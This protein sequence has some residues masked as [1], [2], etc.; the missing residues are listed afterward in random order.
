MCDL[1]STDFSIR[2]M[3]S[4]DAEA[5]SMLVTELGYR[6]TA[7]GVRQWIESLR[8]DGR[9]QTAFV[10]CEGAS[11]IGWV[12][13]SIEHRLQSPPFAL[14]G[15]LVVKDGARSRGV[16]RAL[17]ARAEAWAWERGVE[18]VRVTSRST[19]ADAHRFYLRDGYRQTKTSFVFEKHRAQ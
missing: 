11:V 8:Q 6:Q 19:R 15:G 7:A 9:A 16:G 1:P 13:I 14:I 2:A 10:A 12:E 4:G 17:S 5:V 3:E 18:T